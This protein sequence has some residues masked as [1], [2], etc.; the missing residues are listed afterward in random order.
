MLLLLKQQVDGRAKHLLFSLESDKQHYQDAKDLL[1]SAFASVEVRKNAAIKKLLD[2]QLKDGEDPFIFISTL[3]TVCESVKTL[4][5]D[6]DE[7]IRYFAWNGLNERFKSHLVQITTKT[8][9]AL[10]EI[11][12]N[13][14]IACERYENSKG[15]VTKNESPQGAKMSNVATRKE[16]THN[17]AIKAE[18]HSMS[19]PTPVCAL[20]NKIGEKNSSHFIYSCPKFSAPADKVE[21]LKSKN[22]C[23]KC[24]QFNHVAGNCSFRFKKRC[25]N[26]KGWHMNY[27]CIPKESDCQKTLKN[28]GSS[29]TS[30]EVSSGVAIMPNSISGSVLPTFSFST[31]GHDKNYRGLKDSGSQHTFVTTALDRIYNFRVINSNVKLTVHGFNSPKD[32]L[33]KTVEVPI[34]I[35]DQ[36]FSIIALLVPQININMKFPLIGK[37]VET[38]QSKNMVF[39]DKLL[40]RDTHNIDNIQLLLGTDYAH[41][42]LGTDKVFGDANPSVYT[43]T[44]AGVTLSGN[45]DFMFQNLS[46]LDRIPKL[47][48]H[49]YT[50]PFDNSP[51]HVYS[52]TFFLNTSFDI[53][54]ADDPEVAMQTN[55]SFSVLND[56]GILVERRLQLAAEQILESECNYY[57]N[58]DSNVYNDESTELNNQLVDFTL[59]KIHRNEEGRIVVPLLWN[60]KVSHF[61]SKN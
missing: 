17:Y 35:G 18:A 48:E 23:T 1:I 42:L 54:A 7:F 33:T 12:D 40:N 32:Y 30:K 59:K 58:Y 61:L 53:S 34:K 8:H 56:K 15:I 4:K 20:C 41:C 26:C 29:Q 50:N 22:G 5:I 39:A 19:P 47:V 14:F 38:M 44:H 31:G 10:K 55:S 28:K 46:Y 25:S 45:V 60:G 3:R 36:F 37:I 24:A 9:P 21:I 11:L 51:L 13:F 52:N 43:E 2:L 27:L 6:A 49:S 57:L 16:K